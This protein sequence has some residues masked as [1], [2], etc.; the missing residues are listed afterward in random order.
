MRKSG[1]VSLPVSVASDVSEVESS[2]VALGGEAVVVGTVGRGV[3]GSIRGSVSM[4]IGR[5]RPIAF[6]Q[7]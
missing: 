5:P 2:S 1:L 6:G 7:S 4:V 3:V